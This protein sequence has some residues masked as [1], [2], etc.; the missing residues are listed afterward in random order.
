MTLN[1]NGSDYEILSLAAKSIG[2]VKGLTV[3]I[4]LR[5]GGGTKRII[6]G[7]L[8]INPVGRTHIA[9]DPYGQI[10]YLFK[11]NETVSYDYTNDMRNRALSE[12]YSYIQGKPIN[13]YLYPME[14]FEFFKRF[15]DGVPIY[16]EKKKQLINHYALVYFDGPH[17]TETTMNETLFFAPRASHEAIFVYD[18]VEGF[19]D[20]SQI[21]NYLLKN[22]WE[23]FKAAK[24]KIA[25]KKIN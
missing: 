24:T 8:K 17:T 23:V 19:Y 4:G 9:I 22:G 11:D 13:F 12:L 15:P 10:D 14:D 25:Y 2:W 20:H 1:E 16:S 5:E 3:E 7:L 21:A 18:D 6:D